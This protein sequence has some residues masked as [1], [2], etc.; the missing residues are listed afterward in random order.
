MRKLPNNAN[1]VQITHYNIGGRD[2]IFEQVYNH[3]IALS[4]VK[5][6]MKIKKPFPHVN[7]KKRKKVTYKKKL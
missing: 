6:T 1:S 5:P 7:A 4:K 3:H 2:H